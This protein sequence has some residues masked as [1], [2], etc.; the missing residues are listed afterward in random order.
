M[1]LTKRVNINTGYSC[2]IKCKF[3]YYREQK[4]PKDPD[5]ERIKKD[6]QKA[7][8]YGI[9]I[10][11]LTGGE[12]T[13]RKDL[14]ELIDF[15]K[16]LGFKRISMITNGLLLSDH[17]FSKKLLEAG[18]AETK[19]SIHASEAKMHDYLIG[20]K[21]GFKKVLKGIENAQDLGFQLNINV[22][23]N[24]HN[25]KNLLELTNLLTKYNIDTLNFIVFS[26]LSNIKK[27]KKQFFV[28]YSEIS[29]KIKE[30]IDFAK[31]KIRKINVRYVPFCFMQGYEKYLC[32]LHQ[33]HY[34][35]D[36]WDYYIKNKIEYGLIFTYVNILLSFI[37]K[38]IRLFKKDFQHIIRELTINSK[39][40]RMKTKPKSCKRCKYNLI[41]DGLW[42]DY[43]NT[44][45]LKI[46]KPAL[47]E[48]I[49]SPLFFKEREV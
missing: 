19:F 18:L 21:G 43:K 35:Q 17:R 8:K 48:K 28:S 25:Y 23:V 47:G 49:K 6:L 13:I 24:K 33:I 45:E 44:A 34:D 37:Y 22:V 26:P 9:E 14:F 3:C 12:P 29:P 31:R 38:P 7:K 36:E 27:F 41:C 1:R 11:E 46:L 16:K 40:I 39:M 15:A 5:T 32:N 20:T 10:V 4:R 30:C 2:N 42:K